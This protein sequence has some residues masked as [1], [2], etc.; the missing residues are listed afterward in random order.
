LKE[1]DVWLAD[2]ECAE[3]LYKM[4]DDKPSHALVLFNR[5]AEVYQ[6]NNYPGK[7]A[8]A[9][10]QVASI[11]SAN[12]VFDEPVRIAKE[13]V[14]VYREIGDETGEANGYNVLG[15]ICARNYRYA[16]AIDY[17]EK[18]KKIYA[19]KKL[20]FN[21]LNVLTDLCIIHAQQK[22]SNKLIQYI[23]EGKALSQQC[24]N[25]YFEYSLKS[26]AFVQKNVNHG[27]EVIKA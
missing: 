6:R 26:G 18:A 22:M 4:I 20:T 10:L 21:L 7:A 14:Q 2:F 19:D 8:N 3:A 5:V 13:C 1:K 9:M 27:G 24:K 16:E 11:K 25:L 23:T 15:D 17:Y 12:F